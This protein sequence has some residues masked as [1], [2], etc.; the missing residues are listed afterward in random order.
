MVL[1]SSKLFKMIDAL[2]LVPPLSAEI[3]KD[4]AWMSAG[5]EYYINCIVIGG[6]PPPVI[7]WWIAQ[8][9][10]PSLKIHVNTIYKHPF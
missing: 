6:R 1:H 7:T 8:T 5:R 2:F 10:L 4:L 9:K 3:V